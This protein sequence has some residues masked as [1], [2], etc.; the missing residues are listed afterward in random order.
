M[1]R[2]LLSLFLTGLCYKAPAHIALS[3]YP[4]TSYVGVSTN[5]AR[6][7]WADLRLQTNT[8]IGFSSVEI[9]PKLNL[10]NTEVVKVYLGAGINFNFAQG[11]Y[12]GQYING[13]FV[14][15]GVMASPFKEVRNL[16]FIFE[17]SPYVNYGISDGI[18]RTTLGI[19]WQFKKK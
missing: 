16:A 13:Y 8:F 1:K 19:S 14:S 18:I 9:S 2:L 12:N 11:S 17:A 4:I 10:K 7:L 5:T 3:Y 6:T 15:G